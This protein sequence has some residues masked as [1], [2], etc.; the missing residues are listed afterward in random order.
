VNQAV[1]IYGGHGFIRETGVEQYVRD[2][3]IA[4]IYE[5]T[6]QIQALD[7]LGRKILQN[8]AKGLT[9]F[10]AEM[11]TLAESIE[12]SLPEMAA[13]LKA[14]G[15]QWAKL[16]TNLCATATQD[17]DELGAAA[18]DYLFYSGYAALAYCWAL[19][20]RAAIA[21]EPAGVDTT[22]SDPF[23][24]GKLAVARFYFARVLPRVSGHR[25]AIEA[26][27]DTLMNVSE[28]ALTNL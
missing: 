9:A 16:T 22:S 5:G 19:I 10:T 13:E 11:N 27:K 20:A 28:D 4:T 18:V 17:L 3:R 12:N 25:A 24:S 26:G 7:L 14:L 2:V 6:T 1:Q 21:A 8:Q 23:V 15:E